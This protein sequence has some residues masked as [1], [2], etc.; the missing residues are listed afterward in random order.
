MD[1]ETKAAFANLVKLIDDHS[2]S[3]QAEMQTLRRDMDRGF[4]SIEA[5]TARGRIRELRL[6]D[7]SR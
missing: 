3:L 5:A 2:Q 6:E 7:W 1:L 4:D